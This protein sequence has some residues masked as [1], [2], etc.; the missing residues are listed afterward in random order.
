MFDTDSLSKK[1]FKGLQMSFEKLVREK[2]RD[3][4]ELVFEED[5]QIVYVKAKDILKRMYT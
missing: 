1:I 5:G 3:D 2:A 4:D